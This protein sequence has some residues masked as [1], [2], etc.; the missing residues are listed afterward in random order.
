MKRIL[1][2][3]VFAVVALLTVVASAQS[4]EVSQDM[5]GWWQVQRPLADTP[6]FYSTG[7]IYFSDD[8]ITFEATCS[9]ARGPELKALASSPLAYAP[10]YFTILQ[11]QHAVTS[12]GN[13]NCVAD[14]TAGPIEYYF[15]S[16]AQV[17]GVDHLV[18]FNRNT[19]FQM[20]LVR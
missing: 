8:A 9:F 4:R 5:Y 1:N 7:K 16:S 19:G 10:G 15:R 13:S 11:S 18:I 6:D 20:E 2:L 17:S 3:L 12:T 14:L